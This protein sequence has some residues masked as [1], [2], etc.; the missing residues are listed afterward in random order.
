MWQVFTEEQQ[1]AFTSDVFKN[2][3]V[4][5]ENGL[6]VIKFKDTRDGLSTFELRDPQKNFK[7]QFYASRW[8][9]LNEKPLNICTVCTNLRPK[10]N[11]VDRQELY[12]LVKEYAKEIEGALLNY[13]PGRSDNGQQVKKVVFEASNGNVMDSKIIATQSADELIRGS[14]KK[15]S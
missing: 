7:F 13:P 4:M 2:S 12:L 14:S 8:D 3:G 10:E 9:V 5:N 6:Q 11:I 1:I 15:A